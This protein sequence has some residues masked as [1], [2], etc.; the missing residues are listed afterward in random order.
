MVLAHYDKDQFSLKKYFINRSTRILPVY[1]IALFLCLAI[2]FVKGTTD[3][4]ATILNMLFFLQAW[5]PSYPTSIN[6]PGWFLS[7]LMSFYLLFPLLLLF[8]K[9]FIPNSKIVLISAL[10]FWLC[11]QM[12]L[13]YLLNTG[14]YQ[15]YPS[16]SHDLIYYFPLISSLQFLFRDSGA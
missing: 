8:L 1:F 3:P 11:T 9:K 6:Y 13:F 2:A 10:L 5:F 14:F 4:V 15:G 12:V 16:N 7:D